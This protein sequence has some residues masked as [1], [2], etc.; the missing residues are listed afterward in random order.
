MRWVPLIIPAIAATPESTG[1]VGA[2]TTEARPDEA[3]PLSAE[4]TVDTLSDTHFCISQ[5][6]R[7]EAVDTPPRV[8]EIFRLTEARPSAPLT[9]QMWPDT[10]GK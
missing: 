8:N 2:I 10:Q 6:S 1:S 4:A 7:L 3:P 9:W 5:T